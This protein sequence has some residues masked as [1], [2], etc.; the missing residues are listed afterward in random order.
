M[1]NWML[2]PDQ[3]LVLRI[4]RPNERRLHVARFIAAD[5][6]HCLGLGDY[7]RMDQVLCV[8][9][10]HNNLEV[11]QDWVMKKLKEVPKPTFNDL[12]TE[13]CR[14]L[15]RYEQNPDEECRWDIGECDLETSDL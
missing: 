4:H 15:D 12:M 10:G 5:L 6:I 9:D 8:S 14:C 1:I 2:H 11:L 13:V 3:P 7:L